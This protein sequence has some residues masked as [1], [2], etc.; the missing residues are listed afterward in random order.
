MMHDLVP[1]MQLEGG[2]LQP[3]CRT[4][5]YFLGSMH[6]FHRGKTTTKAVFTPILRLLN[7]LF[8]LVRLLIISVYKDTCVARLSLSQ[9]P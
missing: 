2:H 9:Q 1:S 4:V 6:E 3:T 5:V 7:G 8:P